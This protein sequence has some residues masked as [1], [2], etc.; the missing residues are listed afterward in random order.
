MTFTHG[1]DLSEL[2]RTEGTTV[3]RTYNSRG[4]AKH[5]LPPF[6]RNVPMQIIDF[7]GGTARPKSS[8]PG[9]PLLFSEAYAFEQHSL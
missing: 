5:Y 8:N 6:L 4:V 3:S 1:K 7:P 2:E 9:M